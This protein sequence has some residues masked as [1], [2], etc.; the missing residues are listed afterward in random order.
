MIPEYPWLE[1]VGIRIPVDGELVIS[2]RGEIWEATGFSCT[3]P[4]VKPNNAYNV[5]R[6]EDLKIPEGYEPDGFC[7]LTEGELYLSVNGEVRTYE[8][9][10]WPLLDPRRLRL[11][12]IAPKT[13]RVV[14]LESDDP[15]IIAMYEARGP[16][17]GP[18]KIRS[19]ERPA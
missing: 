15:A 11:R 12:K 14:I 17:Y 10:I 18:W 1:L 3:Y 5:V 9:G 4:V 16:L 19:E 13:K 7:G 2:D 6:L 8:R